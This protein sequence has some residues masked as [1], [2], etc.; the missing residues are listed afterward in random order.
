MYGFCKWYLVMY[1]DSAF[2]MHITSH[3]LTAYPSQPILTLYIS[4]LLKNPKYEVNYS[5]FLSC[6]LCPFM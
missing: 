1:S 4:I 2:C 3:I 5:V 6:L